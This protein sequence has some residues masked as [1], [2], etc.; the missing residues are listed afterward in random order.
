MLGSVHPT[1]I[2]GKGMYSAPKTCSKNE[3]LRKKQADQISVPEP[4]LIL[5]DNYQEGSVQMRGIF[6]VRVF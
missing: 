2:T 4:Q 3:C 1:Y 6:L 5:E